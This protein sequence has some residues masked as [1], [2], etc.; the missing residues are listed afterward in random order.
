MVFKKKDFIKIEFTGMVKDGDV[1]DSNIKKDLE[2]SGIKGEAKPFIF[3]LGE[4]MFIKGVDEFL[5]G[6]D[7]G[8][9]E[10]QLKPEDAFGKRDPKLIEMLP[11]KVFIQHEINPIPGVMLNFDGRIAKILTV[12]GGRVM[13]DFNNPL[14][15]RE[16]KYKIEV[17]GK[18]ENQKEKINALNDFFFRQELKFEVKDK[19]IILNAKKEI[20]PLLELFKGKYKQILGLELEL[21]VIE[22]KSVEGR[23]ER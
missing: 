19:K 10:I 6:K 23:K 12:S 9:Y 18:V 21:N 13:V 11:I 16:L 17:L 1:F 14:S 20:A 15:G 8:K 4:G 3:C 5:I 22:G 2:K 7:I